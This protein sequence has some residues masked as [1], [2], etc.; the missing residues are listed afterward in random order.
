[1]SERR[2]SRPRAPRPWVGLAA[3]LVLG[4]LVGLLLVSPVFYLGSLLGGLV[5]VGVGWW[6]AAKGD[7]DPDAGERRQYRSR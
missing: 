1:M 2:T 3:G 7:A 5:G 6:L 4:T